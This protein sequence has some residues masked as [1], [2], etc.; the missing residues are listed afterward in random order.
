MAK[1]SEKK[2]FIDLIKFRQEEIA[3]ARVNYEIKVKKAEFKEEQSNLPWFK[4]ELTRNIFGTVFSLLIMGLIILV[5]FLV[6]NQ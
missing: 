1:E 6:G 5:A 4:R 2:P 3:R